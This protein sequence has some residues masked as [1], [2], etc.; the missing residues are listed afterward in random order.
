MTRRNRFGYI[1][2]VVK[3]FRHKGLELFY[4]ED[5]HALEVDYVDYH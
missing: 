3:S 4:R 2:A 1:W 5:G